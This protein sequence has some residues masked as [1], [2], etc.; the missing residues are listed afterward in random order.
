VLANA[1]VAKTMDTTERTLRFAIMLLTLHYF[2]SMSSLQQQ[3]TMWGGDG[4]RSLVPSA[5]AQSRR[6]KQRTVMDEA[7][8]ARAARLKAIAQAEAKATVGFEKRLRTNK[9]LTQTSRFELAR[10]VK[11]RK[12]QE[13]AARQLQAFWRGYLA[14][15]VALKWML[16]RRE[17]AARQAIVQVRA[18]QPFP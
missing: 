18:V 15:R 7:A 9:T 4:S 17:V 12:R 3:K 11:K 16:L 1:E 10:T 13:E 5:V 14:R 6:T 8:A 2:R